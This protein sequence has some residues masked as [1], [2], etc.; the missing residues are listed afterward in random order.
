MGNWGAGILENDDAQDFLGDLM[1]GLASHVVDTLRKNEAYIGSVAPAIAVMA[2]LAKEWRTVP[3][4]ADVI[5]GWKGKYLKVCQDR[6]SGASKGGFM[7]DPYCLNGMATFDSLADLSEGFDH[8]PVDLP[9]AED[10]NET[11][12]RVGMDVTHPK[13]GV[14]TIVEIEDAGPAARAKVVFN[15]CGEKRLVL[16]FAGLAPL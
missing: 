4:H 12:F 3:P 15:S 13:F 7:E 10:I 5:K 16:A 14:G 1:D 9:V 6:N 11:A 8:E 2:L